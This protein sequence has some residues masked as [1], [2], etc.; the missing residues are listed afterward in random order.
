MKIKQLFEK[1]IENNWHVKAGCFVM[2]LFLYIFN[3][4][5]GMV[6]KTIKT[7]VIIGSES[8]FR[9]AEAFNTNVSILLRGKSSA[10][11]A[12]SEKDFT[13][14]LD[15]SYVAKDGKYDFPVLLKF[16]ENVASINPLEIKVSPE[17]ISLKVEEEIAA[18]AKVEP[19]LKGEVPYGYQVDSVSLNPEQVKIRGARSLVENC[20]S[21]QTANIVL[22]NA[23]TSF[24]GTAEVENLKK[25]I[26]LETNSVSYTIKISEISSSKNLG[27]IP[28]TAENLSKNLE[29]KKMV[30]EIPLTVEGTL[31]NLEKFTDFST[32]CH[33]DM[34]KISEPG[35]FEVPLRYYL[36]SGIKPADNYT[37]NVS[38]TVAEK[39]NQDE[40]KITPEGSNGEMMEKI[41]L[42]IDNG[43][44]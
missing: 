16:G 32:I 34:S 31:L 2:A 27:N 15:F 23:K 6:S 25:N 14:Y 3:Q 37:K 28:V 26:T 20:K 39:K 19:L 36:P 40:E 29:I 42:S 10:I 35:T 33:A 9:P 8:G 13:A 24:S 4:Q 5:S 18:F 44:D 12:L 11:D 17:K 1:F 38:V 41:D 7:N 43:A 30:S 21:L 22:S